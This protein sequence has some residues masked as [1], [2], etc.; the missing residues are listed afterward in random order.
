MRKR[1]RSLSRSL[2]L[3]LSLLFLTTGC[4]ADFQRRWQQASAEYWAMQ[5]RA[6]AE[7]VTVTRCSTSCL[8]DYCTQRCTTYER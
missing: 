2:L 6:A 8:L 5:A 4:S 1:Y 7:P 3:P